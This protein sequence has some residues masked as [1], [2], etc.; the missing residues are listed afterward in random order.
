MLRVQA[1]EGREGPLEEGKEQPE[2]IEERGEKQAL[3][4][5]AGAARA[6]RAYHAKEHAVQRGALRGSP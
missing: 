4:V 2:M 5:E 3:R 6:W 1:E